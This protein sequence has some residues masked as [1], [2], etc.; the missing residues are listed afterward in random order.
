[1]P[2]AVSFPN[3]TLFE[4]ALAA[5][6]QALRAA[7][8]DGTKIGIVSSNVRANITKVLLSIFATLLAMCFK[9]GKERL[10]FEIDHR[11]F[12][13]PKFLMWVLTSMCFVVRKV[14]IT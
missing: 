4:T 12:S 3:L 13:S 8:P 7:A 6:R 14:D 10:T 2:P 11:R 9:W 1:M 5:L